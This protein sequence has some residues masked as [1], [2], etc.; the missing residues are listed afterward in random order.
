M[1]KLSNLHIPNIDL[2]SFII[3][4]GFQLYLVFN[5]HFY[6]YLIFV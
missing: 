4:F 6:F 3:Q 2:K 5:H 1:K